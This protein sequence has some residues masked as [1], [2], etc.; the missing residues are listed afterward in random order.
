MLVIILII[1]ILYLITLKNIEGFE[2]DD[3]IN[4]KKCL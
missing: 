4:E 1:V 3:Y 2:E